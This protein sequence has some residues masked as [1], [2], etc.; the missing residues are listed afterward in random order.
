MFAVPLP[1]VVD[2]L[3]PTHLPFALSVITLSPV[4][5]LPAAFASVLLATR[6]PFTADEGLCV[7]VNLSL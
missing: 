2:L 1:S 3:P 4:F 5:A 6:V 7:L